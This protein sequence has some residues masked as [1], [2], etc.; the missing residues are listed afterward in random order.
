VSAVVQAGITSRGRPHRR[1]LE[2]AAA[3]GAWRQRD[4]RQTAST[5]YSCPPST[6][7][8][9]TT[10]TYPP[11]T[12]DFKG[13]R[14]DEDLPGLIALDVVAMSDLSATNHGLRPASGY[15][16]DTSTDMDDVGVFYT[17]NSQHPAVCG[18]NVSDLL[19]STTSCGARDH[20]HDVSKSTYDLQ[21]IELHQ[22]A[23]CADDDQQ[24]TASTSA[25]D[26]ERAQPNLL[27]DFHR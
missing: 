19:L 8:P 9:D 26:A 11:P 21:T 27:V 7:S 17:T 13:L 22:P 3:A 10:R 23:S 15:L 6:Y 20:R 1:S 12:T 5:P 2:A 4:D 16:D 14:R 24:L 25:G 18:P